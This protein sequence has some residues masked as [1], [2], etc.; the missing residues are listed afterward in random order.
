MLQLSKGVLALSVTASLAARACGASLFA[1]DTYSYW[2]K[3]DNPAI[4]DETAKRL[5]E[6]RMEAPMSTLGNADPDTVELLNKFGGSPNPLFSR[7]TNGKDE[8]TKTLLIVRG[9]DPQVA[10]SIRDDYP[11]NLVVSHPS[12]NFLD[13]DFIGLLDPEAGTQGGER[14]CVSFA[15][16]KAGSNAAKITT[17]CLWKDPFFIAGRQVFD[18][19]LL[20]QVQAVESWTSE[21]TLLSVLTLEL[22]DSVEPTLAGSL[23]SLFRGLPGLALDGNEVTTLLL[24]TGAQGLRQTLGSRSV[25]KTNSIHKISARA[26]DQQTTLIAPVC[27]ASNSSCSE[28]TNNCSGHGFCYKKS[29][30]A[31][32]GGA[33]DCYVCKCQETTITRDD[34]TVQKVRWGGA[35]CQKRDIS[36]PFFLIAGITILVVLAISSAIGMLFDVGQGE[37]PGVISAG[38]GATSSQK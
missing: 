23:H 7:P 20:N 16:S 12:T 22:C 17:D 15:D 6:L 14:H 1:F 13:T 30:A 32:E 33:S 28:A 24:P 21:D 11:N 34:G 25:P 26:S 5:L 18:E 36:S 10:S 3:L 2:E 19:Q 37:L 29:S 38:V 4:S 9:V 8:I 27:H 31:T 35:A